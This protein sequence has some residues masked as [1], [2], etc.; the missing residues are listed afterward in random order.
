MK[1]RQL[2]ITVLIIILFSCSITTIY[3]V[4]TNNTI[5]YDVV[6]DIAEVYDT[7][8]NSKDIQKAQSLK[9]TEAQNIILE[10]QEAVTKYGGQ[11]IYKFTPSDV[12]EGKTTLYVNNTQIETK[13]ITHGADSFTWQYGDENILNTYPM[14]QYDMKIQYTNKNNTID[15][16]NAKL[17]I[18]GKEALLY[19]INYTLT[20][21]DTIQITMEL[22]DDTEYEVTTGN[23]TLHTKG[24]Y[25]N[26]VSL[27]NNTP[28]II[29]PKTYAGRIIDY[30][31][32]DGNKY[33]YNTTQ[34]QLLDIILPGN[35]E[36]ETKLEIINTSIIYHENTYKLLINTNITTLNN[37]QVTKGYIEAYNKTKL[38][39]KNNNTTS[40]IIPIEYNMED[41]TYKYI[42]TDKYNNTT[43]TTNTYTPQIDTKL[44]IPYPSM[45]I[46]VEQ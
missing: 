33:Y 12:D 36:I 26:S 2:F 1:Y 34:S 27:K 30:T 45:D 6:E 22:V 11:I 21:E 28:S 8:D 13:N 14:G 4:N 19:I 38:I 42:A 44:Y 32:S 29:I 41:I 17:T 16:N 20:P 3:S 37:T 25:I 23:I 39:T 24:E 35:G 5:E 7:Y 46:K 43:L 9:K 31:Y 15:S 18:H 10:N 40:I